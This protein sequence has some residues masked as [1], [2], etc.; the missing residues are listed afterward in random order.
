M[1]PVG[2]RKP[3]IDLVEWQLRIAANEPLTL[4]Q[5]D[6][7]VRRHSV[8]FRINAEDPSKNFRPCPGKVDALQFPSGD[9]IR[10]DTHLATSDTISPHYDSMVAKLIVSG[11]TRAE[12]LEASREALKQVQVG[13]VTTNVKM[14]GELL[15]WSPFATGEYHTGS[16]ETYLAGE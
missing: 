7:V 9:G 10:V 13:G 15:N 11:K 5:S 12:C 6:V 16:L 4:Q 2:Q 3:S 1:H 8:E 14:M